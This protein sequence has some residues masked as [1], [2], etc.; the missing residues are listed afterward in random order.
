MKPQK[1]VFHLEAPTTG[2]GC[3]VLCEARLVSH[4]SRPGRPALGQT[5]CWPEP[6]LPWVSGVQAGWRVQSV[7]AFQLPPAVIGGRAAVPAPAASAHS[8]PRAGRGK[9]QGRGGWSDGLRQL[10]PSSLLLSRGPRRCGTP[11]VVLGGPGEMWCLRARPPMAADGDRPWARGLG[12]HFVAVEH[13]RFLLDL[14]CCHALRSPPVPCFSERN[15]MTAQPLGGTLAVNFGTTPRRPSRLHSHLFY[16]FVRKDGVSTSAH[17]PPSPLLLR[18]AFP[19]GPPSVS[20][21]HTLT[22]RMDCTCDS[23]LGPLFLS[24]GC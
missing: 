9:V 5:G 6:R 3:R 19:W 13:R 1:G 21:P 14:R 22:S 18:R 20:V 7:R 16:G 24:G 17:T 23:T 10:C 4:V 2:S 15:E 8:C 11:R 12:L